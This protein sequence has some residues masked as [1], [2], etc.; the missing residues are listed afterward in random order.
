LFSFEARVTQLDQSKV[1]MDTCFFCHQPIENEDEYILI[2]LIKDE[3]A[4]LV[5]A[6][7]DC[8]NSRSDHASFSVCWNRV[9]LEWRKHTET[10][11]LQRLGAQR[12]TENFLQPAAAKIGAPPRSKF[13]RAQL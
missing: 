3:V 10:A 5:P 13:F 11:I 4:E 9:R 7:Q 6:H 12:T 1:I 8:P 2:E